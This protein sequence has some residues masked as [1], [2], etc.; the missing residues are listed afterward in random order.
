MHF[1]QNVWRCLSLH[2]YQKGEDEHEVVLLCGDYTQQ[3]KEK[4][5][6]HQNKQSKIWT[7]FKDERLCREC[8][9]K[10]NHIR[11]TLQTIW[12][13]VA[14]CSPFFPEGKRD[15]RE[16]VIKQRKN[17]YC[18]CHCSYNRYTKILQQS[19]M[20]VLCIY[21]FELLNLYKQWKYDLTYLLN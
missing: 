6:E 19:F 11:Q 21:L 14:Y 5:N 13:H 7:H 9:M 16:P 12:M 4:N 1:R 8:K 20:F 15:T 10:K 2:S 18:N 3:V 17:V